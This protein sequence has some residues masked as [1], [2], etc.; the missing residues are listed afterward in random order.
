MI[1]RDGHTY[2]CIK[3]VVMSATKE[4]A[5]RKGR[6]YKACGTGELPDEL[7]N[8]HHWWLDEKSIEEY[9]IHVDGNQ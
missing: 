4:I 8:E 1:I 6:Y 9:F 7:G 3:D 2:L 5:Y